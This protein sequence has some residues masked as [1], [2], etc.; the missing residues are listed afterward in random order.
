M[1]A[2]QVGDSTGSAV[3]AD[4]LELGAGGLCKTGRGKVPDGA[5]A[6]VANGY[7]VVLE[8][9]MKSSR[10]LKRSS[11]ALTVIAEHAELT[12]MMGLNMS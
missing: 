8:Y 11:S 9:S 12:S 3:I 10:L 6:G 4:V 2:E 1:A 5:D 7:F